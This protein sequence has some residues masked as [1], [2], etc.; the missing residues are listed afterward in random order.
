MTAVEDRKSK[1]SI[2]HPLYLLWILTTGLIFFKLGY[3]QAIIFD[4]T[5]FI[6]SAQKYLNGVFFQENHPPLGKL[7]IAAGEAIYSRGQTRPD[8]ITVEKIPGGWP[9][10]FDITGFRVAPA[11]FG[12]FVPLFLF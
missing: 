12:T 4:E 7:L 8:F 2:F 3:P 10:N 11:F 9:S 6:P 1:I 5:Y